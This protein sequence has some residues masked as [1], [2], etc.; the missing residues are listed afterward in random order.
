[1]WPSFPLN[2]RLLLKISSFAPVL[3]ITIV[4]DNFYLLIFCLM[5]NWI[6]RLP[7]VVNVTLNL[8][9]EVE[10]TATLHIA[11]ENRRFPSLSA[12]GDVLRL[13]GSATQ[14]QKFQTDD[15]TTDYKKT[16]SKPSVEDQLS[17]FLTF[18]YFLQNQTIENEE[19]LTALKNVSPK[20]HS[21]C[22]LLLYALLSKTGIYSRCL[23]HRI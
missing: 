18:C 5:S 15:Y 20:I 10:N 17:V 21:P 9:N 7:S 22:S 16:G 1:M 19:L 3:S 12:A 8:S 23:L 4:V 6:W 2:C 11:C 13:G 14:G